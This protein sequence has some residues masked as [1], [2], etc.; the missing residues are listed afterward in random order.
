MAAANIASAP[1]QPPV[2]VPAV[3]PVAAPVANQNHVPNMQNAVQDGALVVRG[4]EQNLRMNAQGGPMME[5][6]DGEGRDW[7]DWFYSG[8]RF[9]VLLAIIYFNS[10]LTRFLLVMSTLLIMYLHTVGWFPFR[11]PGPQRP[12]PLQQNLIRAPEENQM[13]GTEPPP[14]PAAEDEP[15]RAVLVPPHQT[16]AMWTAWVFFKTFFSS[17]IPEAPQGLVN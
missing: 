5:E 1:E 10:N 11:R 14:P 3:V 7:L 13:Q 6:E 4:G 9:A 17:L 15:M 12:D 2:P 16:S 8:T